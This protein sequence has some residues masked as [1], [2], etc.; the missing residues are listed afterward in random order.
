MTL[1]SHDKE[2]IASIARRYRDYERWRQEQRAAGFTGL[3]EPYD[4]SMSDAIDLADHLIA[5][6]E[7]EDPEA[8]IWRL[9]VDIESAT[10]TKKR[11]IWCWSTSREVGSET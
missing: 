1:T 5:M 7:N 6:L 10:P 3:C 4:G 8:S 11:P 2:P 9:C